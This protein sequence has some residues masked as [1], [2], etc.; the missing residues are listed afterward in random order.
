MVERARS[1]GTL[2]VEEY[3]ELEE[4]ATTRHEYVGGELYALAGASDRHNRI[5]GNIFAALRSASRGGPCRVYMSDMRLRLEDDT[6]YYPDVMVICEPLES[7][8]P[9]FQR[10]PCLLVEVTSQ[11]TETIDR[12]E[13]LAAYKAIP[14]L[15][16]YLIVSQ[17]R[18]WIQHYRRDENGAWQRGDLVNEGRLSLPCPPESALSVE[19]VYEGL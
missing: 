9:T 3:L 15:K 2:S 7:Q 17:D 16:A 1:H 5:S 12:R 19:E 13:K 4:Q 11:S 6:F 14:T 18:E 8:N 10:E